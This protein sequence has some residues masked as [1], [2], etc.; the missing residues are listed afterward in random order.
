MC[1][2]V[3]ICAVDAVSREVSRNAEQCMADSQSGSD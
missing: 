3:M 2:M 1:D